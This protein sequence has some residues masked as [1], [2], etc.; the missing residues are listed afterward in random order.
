M[1][2]AHMSDGFLCEGYPIAIPSMGAYYTSRPELLQTVRMREFV[3]EDRI[4][5]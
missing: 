2:S 4:L 3:K 1:K 5:C